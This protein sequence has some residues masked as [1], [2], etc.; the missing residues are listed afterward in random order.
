MKKT[1]AILA[2]LLPVALAG[3]AALAAFA[4]PAAPTPVAPGAERTVNLATGKQLREPV[5]GSP[6]RLNSLPMGVAASPDGRYI[7]IL[8]AG[9]GT[10]ESGYAQ[11]IALLDTKSGTVSD[12]PELRAQLQASQTFYEGIAFSA[13]GEHLYASLDSLTAPVGGK[14]G[15]T[16]NAVAVYRMADGK[17]TAERLIAVPLQRLA[18]GRVQDALGQALPPGTAIPAPAGIAV[19]ANDGGHE[20]LLVAD[21]LSDDALLIDTVTGKVSLALRARP[22][23]GPFRPPTRSPWRLRAADGVGSLRCGT[24]RRWPNSTCAAARSSG[25]LPL[26][27]PHERDRAGLA[28]G[29][30]R[31]QPGRA[32]AVRGSRQSRQGCRGGARWL[33][34]ARR[35]MFDTRLPGQTLFGAIPDALAVSADGTRLYAAN[36]GAGRR[37]RVCGAR[38]CGARHVQYP[39]AEP[40]HAM[41]FIP[42]EWYPTA[43]SSQGRNCMSRPAKARAPAMIRMPSEWSM[44]SS[45]ATVRMRTS[46]R[47]CMARSPPS[48]GPRRSS[49]SLR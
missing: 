27:P 7:A 22:R 36:A 39:R 11:S 48:I 42:T 5:P 19:V 26:L 34:P 37:G 44:A 20:Q 6:V 33:P 17:L 45:R 35:A 18:A 46:A 47:C 14:P 10:Y 30:A 4:A 1:A 2:V 23:R 32:D 43:L 8:N 21:E 49:T 40:V 12:F 16:G 41:G 28:S 9:Y 29:G 13:D 31:A 15:Q 24:G 3:P 25:S 38:H